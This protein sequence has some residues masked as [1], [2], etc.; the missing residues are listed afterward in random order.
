VLPLVSSKAVPAIE[1]MT[2]E[3]YPTPL[4]VIGEKS[5]NRVMDIPRSSD[6][7]LLN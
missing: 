5:E 2:R 7:T 4:N 3:K 6:E 1:W